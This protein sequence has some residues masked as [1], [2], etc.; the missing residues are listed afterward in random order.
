MVQFFSQ[1]AV[2]RAKERYGLAL[3]SNDMLEIL[4]ACQDGRASLMQTID[5]HGDTFVWKYHGRIVI[6]T[7]RDNRSFIV[8]FQPA[9]Y[10]LGSSREERLSLRR[11]KGQRQPSST[12]VGKG[13]DRHVKYDRRS[14]KRESEDV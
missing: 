9:D 3:S 10:F 14:F 7:V 6:P 2:E 8:T 4:R 13:A 11:G 5:E 1:H 12:H